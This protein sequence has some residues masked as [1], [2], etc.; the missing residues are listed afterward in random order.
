MKPISLYCSSV[1]QSHYQDRVDAVRK[2]F[3]GFNQ[4]HGYSRFSCYEKLAIDKGYHLQRWLLRPTVLD[5]LRI[6]AQGETL[7]WAQLVHKLAQDRRSA[8]YPVWSGLAELLELEGRA[9]LGDYFTN[10]EWTGGEGDRL[11]RERI[12][13]DNDGSMRTGYYWNIK[14]SSFKALIVFFQMQQF[15]QSEQHCALSFGY[16]GCLKIKDVCDSQLI[17]L[18]FE[19][20]NDKSIISGFEQAKTIFMDR[21]TEI[22]SAVESCASAKS[23]K[24]IF[25][26]FCDTLAERMHQFFASHAHLIPDNVELRCEKFCYY[27][28]V[29]GL[30]EQSRCQYS[31]LNFVPTQAVNSLPAVPLADQAGAWLLCQNIR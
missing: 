19:G 14:E 30:P 2:G 20:C 26:F 22:E 3:L 24:K 25:Y 5:Q 1:V 16:D 21:L 8:T 10:N 7:D 15:A 18:R 17:G 28:V 12:A 23:Y 4:A 31:P 13:S 6:G 29:D 11:I 27:D 9:G